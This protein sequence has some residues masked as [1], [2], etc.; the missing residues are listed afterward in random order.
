MKKFLSISLCFI[1][2]F[3]NLGLAM[4]TH[5]CGGQA[6]KTGLTI[7][8]GHLDCGMPDMD[9]DSEESK[10]GINANNCCENQYQFLEVEDDYR[11]SL[12]QITFN[13]DF[14]FLVFA[15]SLFSVELA[16]KSSKVKY[17]HYSPPLLLRDIPVLN[18]IFII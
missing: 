15:H 9:M 6:V 5:Y 7:G 13:P 16:Q 18:Q 14:A 11:S 2:L 10:Q 3:S 4:A 1:L 17:S 12:V 8:H